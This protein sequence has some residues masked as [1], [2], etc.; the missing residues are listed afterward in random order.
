MNT[1]N[2]EQFVE[3]IAEKIGFTKKDTKTFL[4][5]FIETSEEIL[6]EGDKIQLVGYGSFEPRERKAHEGHNPKTGEVIQVEAK[7]VPVFKAGKGFK[8]A[9]LK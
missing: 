6:A 9:L 2:K 1:I 5:G 7:T 4:E 3:K 8:D